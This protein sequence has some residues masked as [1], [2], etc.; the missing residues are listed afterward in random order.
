MKNKEKL[1]FIDACI[2]DD[3]RTKKIADAALD[4]LNKNYKVEKID[5]TNGDFYPIDRAM[6]SQRFNGVVDERMLKYSK[7]FAS[8][9]RIV[10]AAPFWDM[11]F[12]S[13]LKVFFENISLLNI[14]F[15]DDEKECVGLCKAKKLLFITTRG[16]NIKTGDKLE[17]ASPYIKAFAHLCGI[18]RVSVVSAQNLDYVNNDIIKKKLDCAIKKVLKISEKF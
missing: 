14:T 10:I 11:S 9:D 5:L 16:M 3:S 8:A 7:M 4:A 18:K 2:R 12:P 13:V 15:K 6:L 17:Q 1:L